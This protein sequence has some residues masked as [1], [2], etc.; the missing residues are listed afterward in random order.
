MR[1]GLGVALSLICLLGMASWG[2]AEGP[3]ER[4]SVE[5]VSQVGGSSRAV[6]VRGNIAYVGLGSSLHLVDVSSPGSPVLFGKVTLPGLVE[7][8]FVSASLHAYVANGKFGLRIVDVSDP[9]SPREIGHLDTLGDFAY[10]VFVVGPY[11]YVANGSR[12]LRIIDVSEPA[13]PNEVSSLDTPGTAYDVSISGSYAYLADGKG[14]LRVIDVA[15]SRFPREV[16]SYPKETNL[17]R[18]GFASGVHVLGSYAYLA[19]GE[20]GLRSIN[21]SNPEN[22]I[23]VGTYESPGTGYRVFV[24]FPYALLADG[25]GGLRVIN[26][27]DPSLLWEIGFYSTPGRALGVF[28]TGAL[29]YVAGGDFGMEVVDLFNPSVPEFL[30]NYSFA[31]GSAT[32][33]FLS[34]R[35][36][37]LPAFDY[38]FR[39]LDISDPFFPEVKGLHNPPPP[40]ELPKMSAASIFVTDNW[41][42]VADHGSLYRMVD[43][44]DPLAPIEDTGQLWMDFVPGAS[45]GFLLSRSLS[46]PSPD[47]NAYVAGEEGL[48]NMNLR[49]F[50]D[51][52]ILS[53]VG[54]YPTVMDVSG[55]FVVG[56]LAYV[57]SGPA[58]LKVVDVSD[59]TS[60]KEIGQLDTEGFSMGVY[61]AGAHAYVADGSGG[62]RIINISVPASP[63][64]VGSYP[65][66]FPT[67]VGTSGVFVQDR[68]AYVADGD[69]GVAVLDISIPSSPVELGRY[70]SFDASEVVV[71]QSGRYAF[72][73]DGPGGLLILDVSNPFSVP[74]P[75]KVSRLELGG[76]AN[77]LYLSGSRVYVADGLGGLVVVDVSNPG[78]PQKV[79]QFGATGL[80]L[81][82]YISVQGDK[83][84]AFVADNRDGLVVIDVSDLSNP[85]PPRFSLKTNDARKV[86]LSGSFA[87][88]SDGKDGLKVINV[89]IPTSPEL[90]GILGAMGPARKVFVSTNSSITYA[91]LAGDFGLLILDVTDPT[92]PRFRGRVTLGTPATGIF[93]SFPYAYLLAQT[94]LWVVDVSDPTSPRTLYDTVPLSGNA[95]GIFIG[96]PL[97]YVA[98][99]EFG[100]QIFD[101]TNPQVRPDLLNV[102]AYYETPG[103][104]M[105]VFLARDRIYVADGDGGLFILRHTLPIGADIVL[106]H[107]AQDCGEGTVLSFG[108]VFV[109]TSR[110]QSFLIKNG[111]TAD[112]TVSSLLL[113]KPEFSLVSGA[114][115][116]TL[117]PGLSQTVT[118]RFAPTIPGV[119]GGALTI[120]SN[121]PDEPSVTVSLSGEGMSAADMAID[122]PRLNFGEVGLGATADLSFK[123]INRGSVDLVVSELCIEGE[124]DP[125]GLCSVNGQTPSFSRV[126][127]PALPFTLPPNGAQ[128]IQVRFA[129]TRSTQPPSPIPSEDLGPKRTV[130]K[131]VSND[132]DSDRREAAKRVPL[133]GTAVKPPDILI[134]PSNLDFG[135]VAIGS[136]QGLSFDISNE[137]ATDLTIADITSSDNQFSIELST[138]LPVTLKPRG[139][140]KVTA[141]VRFTPNTQPEGDEGPTRGEGPQRGIM[142][143]LSNDPELILDQNQVIVSGIGIQLRPPR[144]DLNLSLV[145]GSEGY[146]LDFGE[147]PV[148]SGRRKERSFTLFN[149]GSQRLRITGL[150]LNGEGFTLVSPIP[151][152]PGSYLSIPKGGGSMRVMVRFEPA[153]S[154]PQTGQLIVTSDDPGEPAVVVH[155]SGSGALVPDIQL[156]PPVLS[157]DSVAPG[158]TKDL[159]FTV[160]NPGSGTLSVSGL[161][162]D[163]TRFK[164]VAP[165]APFDVAP[166]GAREVSLRF[167][168]TTTETQSGTLSVVSN[169]PDEGTA[170]LVLSAN[171]AVV[172]LVIDGG[173]PSTDK[174][175]VTLTLF[176]SPE[177][178]KMRFS[179][180]SKKWSPWIKV[181]PSKRWTLSNGQTGAKTVWGQFKDKDGQVFEAS[182]TIV[183]TKNQKKAK[184]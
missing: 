175:R 112:L 115:P 160:R 144:P 164:V 51:T 100:L 108:E 102:P 106:C 20:G 159:S 165:A 140:Q 57:A 126:E 15:D 104:A 97:A 2:R 69:G 60:P 134:Q 171:D 91:Y 4:K 70:P 38:G 63:R 18:V 55:T 21:V 82:V 117:A 181:A 166:G 90:T 152:A 67:P 1:I 7:D 53:R 110:D 170:T 86:F 136:S 62:L 169:D 78:A 132:P 138:P 23:K 43:V 94:G 29:A 101:F 168:P 58:G 105:D 114:L 66:L 129:P 22:P 162:I 5:L 24:T 167:S 37:Y 172:R 88:V 99:K 113:D 179:N 36:A 33:V 34:G 173:S 27:E 147:L 56:S 13:D 131:I 111:G 122:P 109:G 8:I 52:T 40:A 123:V 81:G 25:R 182:D 87:Y 75:Q 48:T 16:G 30:G 178:E 17:F 161:S 119:K 64:E 9:R 74:F 59:P 39:I 96:G 148:N 83:T 177:I 116:F 150:S 184:R 92:T 163:N 155:L 35:H 76:N 153:S 145:K 95:T 139:V 50:V 54:S 14:G 127:W 107:S 151:P 31:I 157:F 12:G 174:R 128:D 183:R 89:S 32:D 118:I 154:G 72:V 130:V 146:R 61:V 93:V 142:T 11:A 84:Y 28:A 71:D 10:G 44:T 137:G 124:A 65:A 19:D 73:A 135:E 68:Y 125:N 47:V 41:V 156:D 149:D 180:D 49:R 98:V 77:G 45:D 158:E 3:P 79:A 143:V 26:V 120:L 85:A 42:G 46:L 133:D 103:E 141:T 176:T 80:A 121:D 6:F